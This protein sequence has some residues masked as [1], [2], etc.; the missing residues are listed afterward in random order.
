I[1]LWILAILEDISYLPMV[2]NFLTF[3][4]NDIYGFYSWLKMLKRQE[5]SI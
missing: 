4:V 1:V 3:F 5:E 2:V